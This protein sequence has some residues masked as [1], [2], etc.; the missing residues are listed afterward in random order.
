MAQTLAPSL[1]SFSK[2]INPSLLPTAPIPPRLKLSR[3][4]PSLLLSPPPYFTPHNPT[5]ILQHRFRHPVFLLLCPPPPPPLFPKYS[6]K[7]IPLISSLN[8]HRVVQPICRRISRMRGDILCGP[9]SG[10]RFDIWPS[11]GTNPSIQCQS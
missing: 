8:S 7:I 11:D 2:R 4:K 1:P 9:G 5:P 6:A 10:E 3:K